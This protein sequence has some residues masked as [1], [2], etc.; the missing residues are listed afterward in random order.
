M[1]VSDVE[2]GSLHDIT[3]ARIHPCLRCTAFADENR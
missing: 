1:W 3:A 2:P